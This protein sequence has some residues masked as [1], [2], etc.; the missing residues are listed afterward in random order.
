MHSY[1][2]DRR[3]S[4]PHVPFFFA[5]FLATM[6]NRFAPCD[7]IHYIN[8]RFFFRHVCTKKQTLHEEAYYPNDFK[9]RKFKLNFPKQRYFK[10][11]SSF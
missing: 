8:W 5:K 9:Q 3:E 6:T 10:K 4:W 7:G 11:R 2:F 1:I